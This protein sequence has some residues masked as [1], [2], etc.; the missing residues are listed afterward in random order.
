MRKLQK[1]VQ[2]D[3]KTYAPG[4]PSEE[5][6]LIRSQAKSLEIKNIYQEVEK[7]IE[8]ITRKEV[9]LQKGVKLYS[10][11]DARMSD[12][13]LREALGSW[14]SNWEEPTTEMCQ[15]MDIEPGVKTLI[16]GGF[17]EFY[18]YPKE[19]V[20]PDVVEIHICKDV[21][22]VALY[23]KAFPNVRKITSDSPYF[24]D[25]DMLV[26]L[27]DDI[28]DRVMCGEISKQEAADM[29]KGILENIF[30]RRPDEIVDLKGIKEI[31]DRCSFSGCETEKIVNTDSM[32]NCW[33]GSF[34]CFK[35][36]NPNSKWNIEDK[37]KEDY[38]IGT[39]LVMPYIK[40]GKDDEKTKYIF[41]DKK[42]T[43]IAKD[44][45]ELP[46][47]KRCA[48]TIVVKD[49]SQINA[50]MESNNTFN[51][52]TIVLDIDT[53]IDFS[54][55][56]YRICFI[57]NIEV[58]ESNPY[59]KSIDGVVYSKDGKRLLKC[60]PKRRCYTF[61]IPEGVEEID[62]HAFDWNNYI[63]KIQ[64][65]ETLKNLKTGTFAK[66]EK[67]STIYIPSTME[68]IE[69][70]CFA[71]YFY[72]FGL[73]RIK[74]RKLPK[75]LIKAISPKLPERYKSGWLPASQQSKDYVIVHLIGKDSDPLE[76]ISNCQAI[77]RLYLPKMSADM[78]DEINKYYN[79]HPFD[80]RY[81]EETWKYCGCNHLLSLRLA[82][83]VFFFINDKNEDVNICIR[84]NGFAICHFLI[85]DIKEE[86]NE[87][88]DKHHLGE[89]FIGIE[90][91][92]INRRKEILLSIV[93]SGLLQEDALA[94]VSD[95]ITAF[96]VL[97]I[98]DAAA[99]QQ[100]KIE[101]KEEKE[102]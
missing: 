89:R 21:S 23:H 48:D 24:L 73:V 7:M 60:S 27:P 13:E 20:F 79:T 100:K 71:D 9:E 3:R 39:I 90:L 15:D 63:F 1:E 57:Q 47:T 91:K 61:K 78:I 19:K 96:D 37:H 25:S 85:K 35:P 99:E 83:K 92:R 11:P 56:D 66:C 53:E 38:M 46:F 29:S 52:K 16:L 87:Y 84:E 12:E 50:I 67:L 58:T 31:S 82:V 74:N 65:P 6:F 28:A 49:E 102:G 70:G 30:C 86:L 76:I 54:L 101:K 80:S 88:I 10:V 5:P 93:N 41:P 22:C 45:V 55:F 95:F 42:I 40:P 75:N 81:T 17:D 8:K 2:E 18:F 64:L 32:T 77:E 14:D 68:Y 72:T 59:Y 51:A 62:V 97:A 98:A 44:D 69:D 94:L 34:Y 4:I 43:A 36:F 33:L 26:R